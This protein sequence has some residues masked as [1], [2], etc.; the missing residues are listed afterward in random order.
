MQKEKERKK[1][2]RPYKQQGN[3]TQVHVVILYMLKRDAEEEANQQESKGTQVHV[4]LK[5]A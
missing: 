5:Q 3:A 2:A 4:H 1:Q